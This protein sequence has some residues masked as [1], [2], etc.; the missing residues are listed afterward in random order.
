MAAARA[1]AMAARRPS[2]FLSSAALEPSKQETSDPGFKE[3][4]S[5]GSGS[6][7]LTGSGA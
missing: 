4:G 2:G 7:N 3:R 6:R 5:C 1:P